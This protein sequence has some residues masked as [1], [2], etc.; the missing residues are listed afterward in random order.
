MN[1][2]AR[3]QAWRELNAILDRNGGKDTPE[4]REAWVRWQAAAVEREEKA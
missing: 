3:D 1:Q 2:E 4:Y